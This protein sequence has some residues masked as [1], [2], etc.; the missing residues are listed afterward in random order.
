MFAWKEQLAAVCGFGV[1]WLWCGFGVVKL[2]GWCCFGVLCGCVNSCC[3]CVWCGVV[4]WYGRC[5]GK[6][7]CPCPRL[8]SVG[9]PAGRAEALPLS[10]SGREAMGVRPGGYV[11]ALLHELLNHNTGKVPT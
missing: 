7:A 1:V 3:V 9:A 10:T 4:W 6:I 5:A 2:F 8:P 11:S